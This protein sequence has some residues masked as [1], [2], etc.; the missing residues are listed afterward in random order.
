MTPVFVAEV[1]VYCLTSTFFPPMTSLR[2]VPMRTSG[3]L[4]SS[5]R[6]TVQVFFWEN[7]M[8]VRFCFATIVALVGAGTAWSNEAVSASAAPFGIQ[9]PDG[10]KMTNTPD[11]WSWT[12]EDGDS[13]ALLLY[14]APPEVRDF[15]LRW[16]LEDRYAPLEE[17]HRISVYGAPA[18]RLKSRVFDRNLQ[19]WKWSVCVLFEANHEWYVFESTFAPDKEKT[20]SALT[21]SVISSIGG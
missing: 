17:M 11:G 4:P 7:E 19:K 8:I 21:E 5:V 15:Q 13:P 10:Y 20:S 18:A 16:G 1:A 9:I 3:S 14:K 6:S 2:R 12:S